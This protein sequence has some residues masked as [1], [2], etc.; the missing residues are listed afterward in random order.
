[1]ERPIAQL[2][3]HIN[4]KQIDFPINIYHTNFGKAIKDLYLHWHR[5]FEITYVVSGEG[6]FY[7]DLKP[8][9]VKKGDIMIIPPFSLHS[10]KP[11]NDFCECKT[12]VFNLDFLKTTT[13]DS[14]SIKYLNPILDRT[15]TFPLLIKKEEQFHKELLKSFVSITKTFEKQEWAYELEIKSELFRILA[16]MFNKKLIVQNILENDIEKKSEKI[17]SIIAYV[18][19]HY[20]SNITI[21]E[22]A[23][24][25]DYSEHHFCRFFKSQTGLTFIEYLNSVRLNAAATLLN[26][27]DKSISDISFEVGFENLSYFIRIF[28]KKFIVTPLKYRQYLQLNG[29]NKS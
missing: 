22:V 23:N 20:R 7:T 10:G 12:L 26:N 25:L 5:E 21:T 9:Q 11:L 4:H 28:K 3:E 8:I 18:K 14:I 6:I 2:E 16:L 17:K 24:Y 15:C 27:T 13:A 19:K 1:M 29:E